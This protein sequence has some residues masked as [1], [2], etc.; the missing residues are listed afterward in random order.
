MKFLKKRDYYLQTLNERREMQTNERL[1]KLILENQ[2]GSGIMG[3]EIKWGDCLLGRLL[4]NIIRK[5]QIGSNLVRIKPVVSRL[6]SAMDELLIGSGFNDLE[7]RDKALFNLALVSEYLDVLKISIQNY[8]TPDATEEFDTLEEI[9]GLVKDTVSKLEGTTATPY[10][11]T[12]F[13]NKNEIIR[14]LKKLEKHLNTLK[15]PEDKK[16]D[17]DAD[18]DADQDTDDQTTDSDATRAKSTLVNQVTQKAGLLYAKNFLHVI[19]LYLLAEGSNAKKGQEMIQ[20]Q[21]AALEPQITTTTDPVKKK[22]LQDKLDELKS[23]VKVGDLRESN[24]LFEATQLNISS[25]LKNLIQVFSKQLGKD[26]A[27]KSLTTLQTALKSEKVNTQIVKIYEQI[28]NEEGLKTKIDENVDLVLNDTKGIASVI[29]G[30]YGVV[31]SKGGNVD[32]PNISPEVKNELKLFFDTMKPCL[33]LDLYMIEEQPKQPKQ[34]KEEKPEETKESLVLRYNGFVRMVKEE[35]TV[36]S[37]ASNIASRSSN[38]DKEQTLKEF[39]DDLRDWWNNN[40]DVDQYIFSKQD[41]EKAKEQLDKKLAAAKDSIVIDGMDPVLEI[42]KCF[43]RAYKIHT[44]QVISSGRT[45][46]AVTNKIFMEYTCFG[47]GTPQNAGESGGPYRNNKLFDLWESNVLDVLKEKKYQKIFSPDTRLKV[48]NDFIEKA[49][50]NLRKFMTDMLNGDDFYGKGG[51]SKGGL[52]SKFLDKYFGYKDGDDA[53]NTHF[54]GISEREDNQSNTP[55]AIECV[56]VDAGKELDEVKAP[57]ELVGSFFS[58]LY[59]QNDYTREQYFYIQE[60]RDGNY[61]VSF[62][63]T[64]YHMKLMLQKGSAGRTYKFSTEKFKTQTLKEDS[65]GPYLISCTRM[66]QAAIKGGAFDLGAASTDCG[67]I[68]HDYEKEGSYDR[69]NNCNAVGKYKAI[70]KQTWQI[71]EI[72]W[73]VD[74]SNNKRVKVN[75]LE[76]AIE[77]IKSEGGFEK[78]STIDGINSVSLRRG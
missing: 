69:P 3:N 75:R 42:V 68:Q 31:K 65:N 57:S 61:Y 30:L 46:G 5:S 56:K 54:E 34:P 53:K 66:P 48:G 19:N 55:D 58:I 49:G 29:R 67:F 47:T 70:A 2:A 72:N 25:S 33:A 1:E 9:K 62:C 78:I 76:K 74:S 36:G 28:R 64:I 6:K 37:T 43:N 17:Q 14:Q 22:Q 39:S 26:E 38:V 50:S 52:Q 45:G 8:G 59:K 77:H 20:K 12:G 21:I 4:N 27:K 23:K 71:Q 13:E 44:T 35:L 24:M 7:G 60:Y 11:G 16:D 51:D 32:D 40:L 10:L 15:E 18:Q 63:K 73:I 41:A